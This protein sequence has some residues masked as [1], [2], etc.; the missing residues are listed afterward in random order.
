MT[1]E[2]PL[3]RERPLRW[4]L[5]LTLSLPALVVVWFLAGLV[6]A[7]I[8]AG[9]E[10]P[11]DDVEIRLVG[12][13]IHYDFRL[14]ATPETRAAFAFARGVPVDAPGVAWVLAGWGARDFYTATGAHADLRPGPVWRA[15]SGDASVLRVDV[16]GPFDGEGTLRLRLSAAQYTRLLAAIVATRSGPEL[17]DAGFTPT[18][19]FFA[20]RGRFDA[21][22]TCNVW[23]GAMLRA[24]G[25]RFGVWT[26]TPQA[27]RLSAAL[28]A[29]TP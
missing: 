26:P 18:D 24:A 23:V 25:V 15:I 9:G 7:V 21:R 27:V 14:P 12:T 19:A 1:N 5:G 29:T 17:A 11:G 10:D 13:A 6:G 3:F 8:P 16:W 2:N 20:A 4:A 28:H 22:R